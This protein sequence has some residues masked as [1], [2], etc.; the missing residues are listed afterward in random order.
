MRSPTPVILKEQFN[1]ADPNPDG[2][3]ENNNNENKS[4]G[5]RQLTLMGH[6]LHGRHYPK[7]FTWTVFA[8]AVLLTTYEADS[9]IK[10]ILQ[11][12]KTEIRRDCC[13]LYVIQHVIKSLDPPPSCLTLAPTLLTLGWGEADPLQRGS[14]SHPQK[15]PKTPRY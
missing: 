9:I 4:E 12:R 10:P 3:R 14:M 1:P 2:T 13:L 5:Q 8:R 11:M 15:A 6:S 7:S